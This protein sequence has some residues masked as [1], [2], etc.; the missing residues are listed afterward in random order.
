MGSQSDSYKHYLP[1]LNLS[2]EKN[3]KN[4]PNDGK[5]HVVHQGH[6]VG[7]YRHVKKAEEK[8]RQM[9]NELGYK[10]EA[11]IVEKRSAAEE[12]IER[13]LESKDLYWADSY[14]HNAGGGKGGRGGI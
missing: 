7:S 13:Y 10:P 2:I 9:I 6:I 14:R 3:T 12:D 4:V 5:F 1:N 11:T 8:F